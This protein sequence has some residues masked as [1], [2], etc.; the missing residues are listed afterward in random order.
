VAQ[1]AER[2]GV[3]EG[4]MRKIEQGNPSVRW[5]AAGSGDDSSS[6]PTH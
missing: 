6:I 5:I 3:T 4:T 1:L 2:V